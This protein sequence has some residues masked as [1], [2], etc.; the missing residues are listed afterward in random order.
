MSDKARVHEFVMAYPEDR[1]AGLMGDEEKVTIIIHGANADEVDMKPEQEYLKGML[2]EMF[3]AG[4]MTL[5][6]W[7]EWLRK[8]QLADHER[9]M[10]WVSTVRVYR[11][12]EEAEGLYILL[13]E[14]GSAKIIYP[15]GQ[16]QSIRPITHQRILHLDDVACE[17]RETREKAKMIESSKYSN[18]HTEEATDDD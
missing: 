1:E 11:C 9:Y 15:N 5:D 18:I 2:G 13:N 10:D 7:H 17:V 6:E 8:E 3:G 16:W 14:D 4:A 12:T